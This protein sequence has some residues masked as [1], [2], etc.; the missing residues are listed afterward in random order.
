VTDEC[1]RVMSQ[2]LR[3]FCVPH[4]IVSSNGT[5][6][7]RRSGILCCSLRSPPIPAHCRGYIF[8]KRV[9]N[10]RFFACL[11]AAPLFMAIV[12]GTDKLRE[13]Q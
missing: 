8:S 12:A 9:Q 11:L 6:V 5:T 3:Y 4:R 7:R 13:Q 2:R 1:V 10:V